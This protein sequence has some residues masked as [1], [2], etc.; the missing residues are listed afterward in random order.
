MAHAGDPRLVQAPAGDASPQETTAA[1]SG[2][3]AEAAGDLLPQI[4]RIHADVGRRAPDDPE[5]IFRKSTQEWDRPHELTL[6]WWSGY[7]APR[8]VLVQH[9]ALVSQY[10][11]PGE[12]HVPGWF[13]AHVFLDP[14]GAPRGG[15]T[16][17][18]LAASWPARGLPTPGRATRAGPNPARGLV[19]RRPVARRSRAARGLSVRPWL[20]H[21]P[22]LHA[23]RER[24]PVGRHHSLAPEALRGGEERP[25]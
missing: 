5:L 2:V 20:G 19:A 3:W 9:P 15:F 23:L 8:P 7:L 22:P 17:M 18:V 4:R 16:P 21:G 1:W 11:D 13:R 6:R 25:V 14:L 24:P 10:G 12:L